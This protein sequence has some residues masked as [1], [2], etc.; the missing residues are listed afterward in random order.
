[1]AR[2]E[3]VKAKYPHMNFSADAMEPAHSVVDKCH[4]MKLDGDVK[5]IPPH[6]V[7]TRDQELQTVK[8]EELI[9]RDASGHLRAHDEARAPSR[10]LFFNP[11]KTPTLYL[12]IAPGPIVNWWK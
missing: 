5:Y 4:T 3:A 6:E 8:T 12:C 1:M 10:T 7:P 9:K 11:A 2:W